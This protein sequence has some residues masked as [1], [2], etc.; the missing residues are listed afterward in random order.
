MGKRKVRFDVTNNPKTLLDEDWKCVVAVFV[1]GRKGEFS[2]WR[3]NDPKELFQMTKGF[4]L[5]F[6]TKEV[7]A[8]V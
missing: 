6:P 8:A 1:E 3:K 7:S 4:L 5:K 2:E